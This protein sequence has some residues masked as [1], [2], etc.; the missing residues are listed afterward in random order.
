MPGMPVWY[1]YLVQCADGTL[2]CGITT[3]VS[4]RLAQHD[5]ML[6]GGARY[7]QSRRPVKLLAT[8]P[9]TGRSE[10][11]RLE[12]AVKQRPQA[13]KLAFLQGRVS[14]E[15]EV[16]RSPTADLDGVQP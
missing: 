13:Q 4:R 5:G 10:A 14:S 6:P 8:K 9:C 7:T 15:K 1:V 12:Y 11:L 16:P 2:Y 3:D